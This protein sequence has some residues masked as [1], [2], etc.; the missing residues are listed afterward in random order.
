VKVDVLVCSSDPKSTTVFD[1]TTSA[2]KYF[3]VNYGLDVGDYLV[4]DPA[5]RAFGSGAF[6]P[7]DPMRH[8]PPSPMA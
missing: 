5:T 1:A 2:P 4:Y 3:P 6:A 7:F 8:S